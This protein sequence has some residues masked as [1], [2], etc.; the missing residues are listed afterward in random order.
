MS[1]ANDT[2]RRS[3]F[4]RPADTG[5]RAKFSQLLPYLADQIIQA[6]RVKRLADAVHARQGHDQLS[7]RND[8][9]LSPGTSEF[10]IRLE[11]GRGR[12]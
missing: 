2:S 10:Q 4:S 3:P 6:G 7:A 9:S 12:G 1:T 11:R 8:F 5:P